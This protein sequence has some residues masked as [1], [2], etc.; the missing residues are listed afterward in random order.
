MKSWGG[1]L[2]P[3]THDCIGAADR[4]AGLHEVL[5]DVG[6]GASAG[7]GGDLAVGEAGH[8]QGEVAALAV[9][10]GRE[11][12]QGFECLELVFDGHAAG[13]DGFPVAFDGEV[14]EVQ[15][16]ALDRREAVGLVDGDDVEP[17]EDGGAVGLAAQEDRPGGLAGVL[18]QCGAAVDRVRDGDQQGLVVALVEVGLVT[19]PRRRARGG[20]VGVG[21]HAPRPGRAPDHP[22]R[23]ICSWLGS[24]D[25]AG[26]RSPA[27]PRQAASASS[28]SVGV[29]LAG[30]RASSMRRAIV[31]I[32]SAYSRMASSAPSSPQPAM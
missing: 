32:V 19:A 4:G 20:S 26:R 16:A 11:G 6:E 29:V 18:D 10:E 12:A 3:P 13:E 14:L 25:D 31:S 1:L 9:G 8:A 17:G 15:F 23:T 28:C 27:R 5:V 22:P 30:S 24:P 2:W 21:L 7:H